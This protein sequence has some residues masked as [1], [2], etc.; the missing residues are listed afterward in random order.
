PRGS[1]PPRARERGGRTVN[2]EG[3][4]D[5][6]GLP[7]VVSLLAGT[8]KTGGLQLRREDGTGHVQGVVWFREGR[9]SGA[10][11]DR[12]RASLVRRVVGS[13]A[14][15]D[16]GLRHAVQRA[17]GGGIGVARALLDSGAVDPELLRQAASEQVVDAV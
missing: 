8:G 12:S 7:D 6:F 15:D 3:T 5:A 4:L 16:T 1:P 13:G 14:V 10:S 2:L 9:I 11:S 17:A